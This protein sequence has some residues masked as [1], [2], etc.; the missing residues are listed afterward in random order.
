MIRKTVTF[1]MICLLA[2]NF[3]GAGNG[4][5]IREGMVMQSRIMQQ[6][7]RFSVC[8]PQD[9][10]TSSSSYPV[11]YMLHGLGDDESSWLEY[12]QISQYAY[13]ATA[14]SEIVPMIFVMPQGFRTYYMND[15]HDSCRY[16]DMFIQE[17][18]P[19]IDR[20]F[21]TIPRNDQRALI[22]YSMGGYGALMLALQHPDVFGAT[23][24]LSISV[25]TD[26]QYMT[27]EASGWDKQWGSIFGAEGKK[28]EERITPYYRSHSPF[29]LL[30]DMPAARISNLRIYIDNGD[31]EQTLCRS[32]E[33][34]HILMRNLNIHH[35]FRVRDGGHSFQYW[36]SALP[37]ALRFMS[38]AF[39]SVP[40]RGDTASD[41]A[42]TRNCNAK[43]LS[44]E[45]PE[46]IQVFLPE[47][48]SSTDRLFPVM[49]FAGI[50]DRSL[51]S[52]IADAVAKETECNML[53]PV[54]LAFLPGEDTAALRSEIRTV[55]RVYRAR[56]GYRFRTITGYREGAVAALLLGTL[57]AEFAACN[58][59]DAF[60]SKDEAVN[61]VAAIKKQKTPAFY[62]DAP[63]GGNYYEGN[64]FAHMLLRDRELQHEYRVR[65]GTGGADWF[66]TGL[67]EMLKYNAWM[68]H[69]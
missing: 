68:I 63:V 48:Y 44:G 17:L 36:T 46:G 57:P 41:E 55:E 67:Q 26:E 38:D 20:I 59:C 12:G 66:L 16:Q 33:E 24:P 21:R 64:G 43:S 42:G 58:L 53:I 14:R 62:I 69:R 19:Y 7:I 40:Y 29:H 25:R 23:V 22:G 10:Y 60:I 37:N 34:L 45:E 65:Q 39:S 9:Y 13:A 8:L 18:V 54:I 1:L 56:K 35:E 32:N 31:D 11:V 3:A 27:E 47:G 49:Y 28:G 30:K 52:D 6:D 5:L 61:A 50:R 15:Y 51:Q 4:L 2:A